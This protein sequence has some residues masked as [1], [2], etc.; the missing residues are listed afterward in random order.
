MNFKAV[1]PLVGFENEFLFSNCD[2]NEKF[3][4]NIVNIYL[5]NPDQRIKEA[6]LA[7]Y[8]AYR[9]HYPKYLKCLFPEQ[10]LRLNNDIVKASP[11][12]IKLRRIAL[13]ALSKVA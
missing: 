13:S 7:V 5:T 3:I 1:F 8:M 10:I 9:D 6:A 4:V 12:V 2:S 11:K